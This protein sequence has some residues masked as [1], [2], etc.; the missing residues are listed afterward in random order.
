MTPPFL[1]HGRTSCGPR[2]CYV[3]ALLSWCVPLARRIETS[4]AMPGGREGH[5]R[6]SLLNPPRERPGVGTETPAKNEDRRQPPV[7]VGAALSPRVT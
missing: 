4:G 7:V 2:H 5:R 3:M 1:L 6:T